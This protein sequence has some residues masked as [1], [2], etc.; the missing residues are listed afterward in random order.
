MYWHFTFVLIIFEYNFFRRA[1]F[2]Y[3]FSLYM[4]HV[5][6]TAMVDYNNEEIGAGIDE[7]Y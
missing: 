3:T 6:R 2:S 1:F 7:Y 4:I 5:L